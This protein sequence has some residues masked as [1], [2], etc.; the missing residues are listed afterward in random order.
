MCFYRPS[1]ALMELVSHSGP[2]F[3]LTYITSM[4]FDYGAGLW[5]QLPANER[6]SDKY[7]MFLNEQT[8][9]AFWNIDL[10]HYLHLLIV[11]V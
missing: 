3:V 11:Y 6:R 4:G 8:P 5:N 1:L 2:Y 9:K 10:I 7:T